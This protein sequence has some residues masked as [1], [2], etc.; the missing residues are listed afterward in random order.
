MSKDQSWRFDG[1]NWV[2]N[3]PPLAPA[4][5]TDKDQWRRAQHEAKQA[6]RDAESAGHAERKRVEQAA[7]AKADAEREEQR[8]AERERA[9]LQ[10]ETQ[11]AAARK[12]I[13]DRNDAIEAQVVAALAG[14]PPPPIVK[15]ISDDQRSRWNG[16]KWL[17]LYLPKGVGIGGG[18][19][20]LGALAGGSRS[21]IAR[22]DEAKTQLI[23]KWPDRNLRK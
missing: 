1:T 9:Q 23:Y 6:Q 5:Q 19:P 4:A 15:F 7:K 21:F 14:E 2:P 17:P 11:Q 12:A 20:P 13:E 16:T 8:R 3:Q 18:A 10:R 22:P